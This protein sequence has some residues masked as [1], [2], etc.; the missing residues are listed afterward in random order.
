MENA[1]KTCLILMV[2]VTG[3]ISGITAIFTKNLYCIVGCMACLG[4]NSGLAIDLF[5]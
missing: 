1:I 3:L 2:L 5:D 4:F